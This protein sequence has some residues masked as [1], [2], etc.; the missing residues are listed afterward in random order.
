MHLIWLCHQHIIDF[1]HHTFCLKVDLSNQVLFHAF[2]NTF[3]NLVASANSP[4]LDPAQA[5]FDLDYVSRSAVGMQVLQSQNR[6]N[7]Y[8]DHSN[9]KSWEAIVD[10]SIAASERKEDKED[11]DEAEWGK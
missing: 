6:A 10:L 7:K 9:P 2:D 8:V 4:L 5:Y 1:D 11:S 3:E